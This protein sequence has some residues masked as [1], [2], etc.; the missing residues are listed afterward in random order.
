[1]RAL[2][3]SIASVGRLVDGLGLGRVGGLT[4]SY[5][6]DSEMETQ[7]QRNRLKFPGSGMNCHSMKDILYG[8][9]NHVRSVRRL[10]LSVT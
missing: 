1:M 6:L 2:R 7:F 4:I 9:A 10:L 8:T 5:A 3:M